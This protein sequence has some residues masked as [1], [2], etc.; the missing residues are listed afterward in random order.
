MRAADVMSHN[1]VMVRPG[2]QIADAIKLLVEHD[3]SAVP[4]V[5]EH[6]NLVGIMSE[7]DLMRRV[8]IGTEKHRPHWIES[9]MG[10]ASL[11]AEFAKSHGRMVGEIMT[12]EVVSVSE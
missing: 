10:A 8:E 12:T 1:V 2:T 6:G 9:L 5:D 3:I 4:V 11:A 7:A